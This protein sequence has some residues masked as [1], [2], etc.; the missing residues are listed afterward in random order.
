[1][2]EIVARAL[3]LIAIVAI[4]LGIKRLGWATTADF[5]LL[6]RIVLGVTLPCALF[7]SFNDYHLEYALLGLT[8]LA[9]AINIGQQAIGYLLAA[10]R[11]RDAQAFAVF[12]SGSYNI[13]A[14]A[15]PYLGGF[16]GPHAMIYSTLFDFGTAFAS[17]G[18][19][20]AWGMSL[21]RGPGRHGGRGLL[22]TL[23]TSPV[24]VTYLV[25]LLMR[26]LDLRL[27][28][29]VITF[30]SVVG[31][32]NP[33]LAMLMIGV[34][35]EVRLPREKYGA[36]A[37][38]LAVRYAFSLVA[39]VACWYLLPV[40]GEARLVVVMLLFAPIAAMM[41]IF[42]ARAGLDVELATF[43]NSVSMLVGIVALPSIYLALHQMV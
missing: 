40:P 22:R 7:T 17:A 35:L 2:L 39:A 34:G 30:T 16:M 3:S 37:R 14:F 21:A 27:P 18:V 10:R 38:L 6:S 12:N 15:T 28:D 41:P 42:T 29:Q 19:A 36:A 25:L 43:M 13:G 23:A 33:F 1:M 32:A 11:G 8:V 31:A 24:F 5:G 4:G 26:L 20:Y 9:L